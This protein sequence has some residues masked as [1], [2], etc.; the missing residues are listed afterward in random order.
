MDK[1]SIII[2]VLILVIAVLVLNNTELIGGSGQLISKDKLATTSISTIPS[3]A[4]TTLEFKTFKFNDFHGESLGTSGF[5][6]EYPNS[7]KNDGQYFSPQKI[8]HFDINSTDA[9]M[10][11]DLISEALI[12]TS[13]LKYQLSTD[14][15]CDKDLD[16]VIDGKKFT[17]YCL[18]DYND[19]TNK[20]LVYIG[21]K[22]DIFGAGYYLVFRWEQKPLGLEIPE[23]SQNAFETMVLSLRFNK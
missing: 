11:Y 9:P 21:P 13:D 20:V 6:F 12:D 7:W 1:K 3:L 23:N 5:E 17:K 15:R 16:V 8:T 10:Y 19:Q 14:K 22:V 2:L 18:I 4:Q